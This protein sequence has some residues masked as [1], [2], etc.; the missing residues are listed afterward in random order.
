MQK[1]TREIFF[2][3][4]RG[5]NNAGNF[6]TLH[7]SPEAANRFK[8]ERAKKWASKPDK[9][10]LSKKVTEVVYTKFLKVLGDKNGIRVTFTELGD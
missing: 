4:W 2:R 1:L 10:I 3:W 5:V 7:P 8:R 6:T 9:G